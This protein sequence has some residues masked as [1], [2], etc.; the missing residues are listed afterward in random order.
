MVVTPPP[1]WTQASRELRYHFG[2]FRLGRARF[3]AW[4][5]AKHFLDCDESTLDGVPAFD[6]VP[7]EVDALIVPSLPVA[8]DLPKL[9]RSG[10]ALRYVPAHFPHYAIELPDSFERY[11]ENL[12]GKSRHEMVRKARRFT[13]HADGRHALRAFRAP[14][15]MAEFAAIAGALSKATYQERLLGVGLPDGPAFVAELEAAAKRDE[16]RGWIL[17]V[18]GKPVAYGYCRAAGDVLLFEHTGYDAATAPHSPGIFLLQEILRSV[19]A[20]RR[21]R[22]FDFGTGEAQY[23]RSYATVS[24]RCAAVWLLRPTL[25]NRAIVRS[26]L[27]LGASSDACV[28]VLKALGIKDR[29]RRL[30]RRRGS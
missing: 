5:L 17:E 16:V 14:G 30:L 21:F 28:R 4:V 12:S 15:E 25:R 20:E 13:E 1:G 9:S 8:A 6:A 11:L 3:R 19:C 23:K 26:H 29:I 22:V 2:E 7:R 24:R 10:G 27:A 18:A